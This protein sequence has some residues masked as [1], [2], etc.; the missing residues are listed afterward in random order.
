MINN[1][2][3]RSWNKNWLAKGEEIGNK[4]DPV[5]LDPL[6]ISNKLPWD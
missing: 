2:I 3:G 4:P 5:P 1:R 6:Q